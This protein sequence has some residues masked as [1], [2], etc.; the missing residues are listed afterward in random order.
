MKTLRMFFAT[1]VTEKIIF[2]F[3][4]PSPLWGEG[5]AQGCAYVA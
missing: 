5:F 2:Y 4:V 3:L 1:E